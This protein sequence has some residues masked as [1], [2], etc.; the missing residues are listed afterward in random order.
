MFPEK[1]FLRKKKFPDKK[2]FAKKKSSL[3]KKIAENFH[4]QM[5]EEA[6]PASK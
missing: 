6:S 3:K 4:P 1:K 2:T 5:A